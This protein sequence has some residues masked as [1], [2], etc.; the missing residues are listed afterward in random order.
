MNANP[1]ESDPSHAER[2][3]GM[4]RRHGDYADNW[5]HVKYKYLVHA[6]EN[7]IVFIDDEMDV[8]WETSPA[9]DAEGMQMTTNT[10][11]F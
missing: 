1:S 11:P 8:D 4:T 10:M 9:Y 2:L 7:F 3:P 5:I 6:A